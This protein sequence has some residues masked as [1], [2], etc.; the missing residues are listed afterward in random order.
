MPNGLF[1]LLKIK[2]QTVKLEIKKEA[3]ISI[4]VK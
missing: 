1:K 4:K 2:V 3:Q